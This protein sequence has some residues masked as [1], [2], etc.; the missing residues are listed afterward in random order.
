MREDLGTLIRQAR[1]QR[2]WEQSELAQRLGSIGQQT[3]SRWE[4]GLS[5]P[6][7]AVIAQIAELLNLSESQLLSAAGHKPAEAVGLVD[8]PPPARTRLAALPFQL[9]SAEEFERFSADLA[10]HLFPGAEA[11]RNGGPGSRQDGVDVI[12]RTKS[13]ELIAIQ[14]KQVRKFGPAK[15]REVVSS[16]RLPAARCYLYLSRTASPEAR[17]EIAKHP[18]WQVRDAND[19]SADVRYLD[20]QAAAIRLIETY[21]GGTYRALFLGFLDP[22]PW[23]TSADF[24]RPETSG[25]IYTHAWTLVGRATELRN[26]TAFVNDTESAVAVIVGRGG[27]GKSRLLCE[28]ARTVE[29]QSAPV[30][31]RFLARSTVVQSRDFESLP[32]GDQI[33]IVI[34]DA[35]DRS[36]LSSVIREI[37]RARPGAKI[38]LSLRPQGRGQLRADLR[39]IG[40]HPSDVREW[41]LNDLELAAAEALAAE[42]LGSHANPALQQQ[43]AILA[44]DCP[45]LIVV[46]GALID[47]GRLN[48]TL[49]ASGAAFREEIMAAFRDAIAVAEP[50]PVPDVQQEVLKAIAAMQPFRIDQPAFRSALSGLTERPFDQ[51]MPHI[52]RLEESAVLIRRG[53]SLRIIPDLLGDVVLTEAAVDLRS[54]T[55]TNYL[56]RALE[57]AEGDGLLHLFANTSRIDWQIRTGYSVIPS[58][59]ESLW[60]LITTR[61]CNGDGMTRLRLLEVLRKVA[62]FQPKA[63]IGLVRWAMA[64]LTPTTEVPTDFGRLGNEHGNRLVLEALSGVL[65]NAAYNREYLR[66]AADLLWEL[67]ERD[68]R[69][70]NQ[71]P[72]HPIRILQGL[73]E[74]NLTKSA[75]FHDP[76]IDAAAGWLHKPRTED[77]LYSPFEVLKP[78]LAT[79]VTAFIPDERSI[80]IK[81]YAVTPTAVRGLRG[82]ALDLAFA[83]IRS[84]DPKW[85]VE[86]MR[87]IGESIQYENPADPTEQQQWTPMFIETI[88]RI[89]D[90]FPGSDLDPVVS[91][92]AKQALWWHAHCS[93]TGTRPAA[94]IALSRLPKSARH[95]LALALH[96]GWGHL[97]PRGKDVAESE[98]LRE[99]ALKEVAAEVTERWPDEYLVG[100]IEERLTVDRRAFPSRQGS[101]RPFIWTLALTR[102]SAAQMICQRVAQNPGSILQELLPTALSQLADT[103]P[104]E[105][106][107]Q[108]LDLLATQEAG[109]TR[110]V[111]EA[112]GFARGNRPHLLE[113][114]EHLLRL[115]L[116]NEEPD[117]RCLAVTAAIALARTSPGLAREL[118]T[119][120]S[121]TDSAKVAE[122]VAAAF[123]S[124]KLLSWTDLPE[125]QADQILGQLSECPSIDTYEITVLLTEIAK[126]Q[127]DRVLSLLKDRVETWET[128]ES[129]R[130]GYQPLPRT[131]HVQPDFKV[132]DRYPALLRSVCN[133]VA[134]NG[135]LRTRL[136]MGAQIFAAVAGRFDEQAKAV[137]LEALESDNTRQAEAASAILREAPPELA[138]EHEFVS[139]ALHAAARHGTDHAEAVGS[140]LLAAAIKGSLPVIPRQPTSEQAGRHDRLTRILDQTPPGSIEE[141][142]YESLARWNRN[143]MHP[144]DDINVRRPDRR[145]W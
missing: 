139:Q 84:Q 29:R 94:E 116:S 43:L 8:S 12:V 21:F 69:P 83:E 1:V 134:E 123:G 114:E 144:N 19:L 101:P 87:A 18:G 113:G 52:R 55:P 127:P 77:W 62:F 26:L 17:K 16:M 90:L 34:D 138:W 25:R 97:L 130:A 121:F 109:I 82:R 91:V 47:R 28:F 65:E 117:V 35:H 145:E 92:A 98:L 122:A 68:K 44:P 135:A 142:F 41:T 11:V 100:Q 88:E 36:G 59:I 24:F 73:I 54:G 2:G 10:R 40:L 137:L 32:T 31:V 143:L 93:P 105:A 75:D 132:H 106:S 86:A 13:G 6:R 95:H 129:S 33:V 112:F 66:Q 131:W 103:L 107:Q 14:C 104:H 56:E 45:L 120:V 20:D 58:L 64:N 57:Y 63:T 126:I 128:R 124:Y 85:A 39:E 110:Y 80:T 115:L 38:I 70:P 60:P 27:I 42:A 15:V 71:H 30:Q 81:T 61:Y 102:P 140:N 118:I 5:R 119:S 46:G 74:Y 141:R 89:G 37:R 133:W 125:N 51:L 3:V 50:A 48:P 4:R 136:A 49:L 78:F 22:G 67:A 99:T 7:R 23:L 9:L 79:T 76:I 96:D 111:A 108:T 53:H 72:G